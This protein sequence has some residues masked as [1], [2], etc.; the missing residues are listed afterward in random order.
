[1]WIGQFSG[2]FQENDVFFLKK[3]TSVVYYPFLNCQLKAEILLEH[4]KWVAIPAGPMFT[5]AAF[6]RTQRQNQIIRAHEEA[7]CGSVH[8]TRG[9]SLMQPYFLSTWHIQPIIPWE[10]KIDLSTHTP[11]CRW[12]TLHKTLESPLKTDL[13][14]NSESSNLLDFESTVGRLFP[15]Q[16]SFI[17]ESYYVLMKYM[18]AHTH[19]H[20]YIYLIT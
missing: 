17:C 8:H 15:L 2:Y 1:M 3:K 9:L 16:V 6:L 20:I 5:S 19:T 14:E 7:A 12:R 11:T 13:L 18:C 4:D 10:F